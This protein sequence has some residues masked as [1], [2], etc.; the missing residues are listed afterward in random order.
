MN[1]RVSDW[2]TGDHQETASGQKSWVRNLVLERLILEKINIAVS[3]GIWHKLISWVGSKRNRGGNH[4]ERK[5]RSRT[6]NDGLIDA[7]G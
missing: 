2:S 3:L 5:I 7:V 4:S 6:T 1:G